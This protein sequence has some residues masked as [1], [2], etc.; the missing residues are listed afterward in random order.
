MRRIVIEFGENELGG[1]HFEVVDEYGRHTGQLCFDEML[2][3]VVN[4][5]HPAIRR[6]HYAMRTPEEWAEQDRLRAERLA[7]RQAARQA[8]EARNGH[9]F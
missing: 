5:T 2:G 7:A 9:P 6:E 8:E 4:L 3:Q 1:Q